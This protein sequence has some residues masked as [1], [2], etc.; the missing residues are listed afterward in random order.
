MMKKIKKI[1][2]YEDNKKLF[3][4][5]IKEISKRVIN[6]YRT[7]Y[8]SDINNASKDPNLWELLYVKV[9]SNISTEIGAIRLCEI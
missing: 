3:D 4:K 9:K 5:L 2:C 6:T 8:H 1:G 7:T